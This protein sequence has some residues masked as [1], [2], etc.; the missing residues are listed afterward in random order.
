ML[1]KLLFKA[2]GMMANKSI[3]RT[4]DSIGED[5]A[6]SARIDRGLTP[7]RALEIL[8]EKI[9]KKMPKK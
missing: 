5:L 6:M 2:T 9:G 7:E 1:E 3:V 8:T 4:C